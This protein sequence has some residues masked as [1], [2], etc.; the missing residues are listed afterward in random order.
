MEN[1]GDIPEDLQKLSKEV[2]LNELGRGRLIYDY[3]FLKVIKY[4]YC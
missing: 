3:I 2:S 1:Q 4:N